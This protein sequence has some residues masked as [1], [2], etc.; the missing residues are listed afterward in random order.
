MTATMMM[1]HSSGC[2]MMPSAAAIATMT[3]AIRMSANMPTVFPAFEIGKRDRLSINPAEGGVER[4]APQPA[5]AC[6]PA[7]RGPRRDRSRPAV[8]TTTRMRRGTGQIQAIDD[9]LGTT[10]AG[11]R[12]E[13]QLLVHVGR[14]AAE[15]AVY[16]VG[17]R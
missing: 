9:R 13:H 2:T 14:A 16:Q 8:H 1:N 12:P 11:D 7:Q 6:G 17:V 10:Q 15:R 3:S 4:A 5:G